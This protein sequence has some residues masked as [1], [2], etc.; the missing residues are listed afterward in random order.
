MSIR[1]MTWV[2]NESRSKK[3]ARLLL[4]AIADCAADDGANAYPS[5]AELMR[6]TGL[7]ERGVQS[8]LLDLTKLGELRIHRNAGPGGCN[9]YQVLMTPAKSAGGA[10]PAGVQNVRPTADPA[11]A[12]SAPPPQDLHPNPAEPAPVTVL[13]PNN[14]ISSSKRSTPNV[15]EAREDV[16]SICRH[17][18]DR[19]EANGSKRPTVTARWRD[20]A[21]LML[22]RDGKTTDQIIRA[23]DWCQD[24]DF[25]RANVMSM[26]K[27]REK[28]DQLRLAAQ[29]AGRPQQH[30]AWTNPADPNAYYGDL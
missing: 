22:D 11:G 13:E 17:L 5:I 10:D 27:L 12:G 15:F 16:D 3:N 24:D 29:R 14:K 30:K 28:Y 4:L 8:T 9:R 6:K 20:A 25:W 18:A 2:W 23:I 1:V 21:R 19:I 7:S 26:P